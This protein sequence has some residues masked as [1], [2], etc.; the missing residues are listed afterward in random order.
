MTIVRFVLLL[1]VALVTAGGIAHARAESRVALVIGNSAYSHASPL[2]NPAN[3]AADVAR[4]FTAT[5]FR[6]TLGLDLDKRAFDIKLREFS[7]ALATADVA[8]VFYAGHALQIGGVNYLVP[9]DAQLESE[10]DL[11]FETVR[12]DVVLNQM[13]IGRE[14]KT[15]I[16]FLDACRDNPLARNLVRSMGTRSASVGRGLAQVQS[17]VGTFI[18]YATQPGNVAL[19]GEG[20]NSPFSAALVKRIAGEGRDL[21]ALMIQV[22]NDVIAATGGRQIPWDHSALTGEFYFKPGAG[23]SAAAD[24]V[25]AL[26]AR[27]RAL[28]VELKARGDAETI[29]RLAVLRERQRDQERA[30]EDARRRVSDMMLSRAR[31]RSTDPAVQ[32]RQTQEMFAAQRATGE[33]QNRLRQTIEEIRGLEAQAKEVP[34]VPKTGTTTASVPAAPATGSPQQTASLADGSTGQVRSI[35]GFTPIGRDGD[36]DIFTGAKPEGVAIGTTPAATMAECLAAC[37][38][39]TG[40]GAAAH[41]A[42]SKMCELFPKGAA[43]TSVAQWSAALRR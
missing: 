28:E 38:R 33:A 9:I 34:V 25:A 35:G 15:N 12:L 40:C 31:D 29:A 19:D 20:R 13:E 41:E 27:T 30:V 7:R 6:V 23:P 32:S 24:Q 21:N 1:A 11:E 5:G 4:A 10:R 26:S 18:S 8:A 43:L 3:D 37:R 17:G 36:A 22:R 14:K 39:H 42:A 2:T 16:V